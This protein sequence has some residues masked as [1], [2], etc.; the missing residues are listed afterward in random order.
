MTYYIVNSYERVDTI[1]TYFVEAA[2]TEEAKKHCYQGLLF[3]EDQYDWTSSSE[4]ITHTV[5]SKE[6]KLHYLQNMK[7]EVKNKLIHEI[8]KNFDTLD[9]ID[10]LIKE[11]E[12]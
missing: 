11:V 4:E 1:Y 8:N 7:D 2:S 10:Q 6:E 9:K 12:K 5:N 3:K